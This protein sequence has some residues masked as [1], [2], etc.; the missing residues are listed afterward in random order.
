MT[1][2]PFYSGCGRRIEDTIQSILNGNT[3]VDDLPKIT[4]LVGV[5]G[6]MF[7]LNNRRLYTFKMLRQQGA[8]ENRVPPNTV[9]VRVK[10]ALPRELKKYTTESCSLNCTIMHES[11]AAVG[12]SILE[13]GGDTEAK[14]PDESDNSTKKDL[15]KTMRY[16]ASESD[17][18]SLA[19]FQDVLDAT[20]QSAHV[21]LKKAMKFAQSG[22]E[23]QC[24]S[25]M[26]RLESGN[27][28]GDKLRLEIE[29]FFENT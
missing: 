23:K 9:N 27:V 11:A 21:D 10:S 14:G 7:S 25:I 17:T 1:S 22:K 29:K 8:L 20:P 18:L 6:H 4:V 13:S 15:P 12:A 16:I 3:S 5:D 2:R 28:I 26:C 24:K 19:S